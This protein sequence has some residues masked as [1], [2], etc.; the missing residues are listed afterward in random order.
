M[1]LEIHTHTHTHTKVWN[2]KI[3]H[4]QGHRLNDVD[5]SPGRVALLAGALP[6]HQEVMGSISG[7][8]TYLGCGL[9]PWLGHVWEVTD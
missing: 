2:W 4:A 6:V 3:R 9:D 1:L 7:Q 8:G 5:T